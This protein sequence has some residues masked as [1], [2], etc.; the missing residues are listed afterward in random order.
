[1][2]FNTYHKKVYQRANQI[3]LEQNRSKSDSLAMMAMAL[4]QYSD[5]H[6]SGN[7]YETL[8][9]SGAVSSLPDNAVVSGLQQLEMSYNFINKLE[10]MHWQLILT[11][12]SRELRGVINYA[13]LKPV[14]IE[15][16]FAVELQNIFVECIYLTQTK[17]EVYKAAMND[18]NQLI[19]QI[20]VLTSQSVTD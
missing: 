11:E 13:K 15:K 17:D 5:F 20:E 10:D 19:E 9:N 6:R 18:M 4:S 7:L 16:L 2:A 12:V 1:M 8:L 14:Q 3:I